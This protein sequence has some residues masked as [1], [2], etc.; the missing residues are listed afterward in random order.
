MRGKVETF[1]KDMISNSEMC[2]QVPDTTDIINSIISEH[3]KNTFETNRYPASIS[4]VMERK[5]VITS[6]FG[7]PKDVLENL[8]INK[9]ESQ[10][11]KYGYL[12]S[13]GLRGLTEYGNVKFFFKGS[14]V[15]NRTT[16]TVGDSWD[17]LANGVISSR[18]TNPKVESIPGVIKGNNLLLLT[19]YN[20]ID[21]NDITPDMDPIDIAKEIQ[22]SAYNYM[23]YA[24]IPYFELQFHGDLKMKDVE[25]C[26]LP[27]YTNP[28]IKKAI[29][30][31]GVPVKEI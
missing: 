14:P 28:I 11:E 18:L 29:K 10:L 9:K 23:D 2:M 17:Q 25:S 16:M 12:T 31:A 4:Y 7:V 8:F 21:N 3:F 19:I 15:L 5:D 20:L 13:R 27:A 6:S 1:F 26:E 22:N 24:S 30:K